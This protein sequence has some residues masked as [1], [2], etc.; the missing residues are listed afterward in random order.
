MNTDKTIKCIETLLH[1]LNNGLQVQSRSIKVVLSVEEIIEL[2]DSWL[3]EKSMGH[4]KKPREITR[5][6][7]MLKIACMLYGKMEHYSLGYANNSELS[8]KFSDKADSAFERAIEFIR[9]M[10]TT[11][12]ELS[13]WLD[14]DVFV[15]A[16]CSPF[17][18]PRIVGSKTRE[19]LNKSNKPYRMMTKRQLKINFL[20]KK[21][22]QLKDGPLDE[23]M[24]NVDFS[25]KPKKLRNNDFSGFIF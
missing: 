17:G 23:F 25:I 3:D 14:R 24:C 20:E 18:V 19:C 5:Y 16:S 22:K 2:R 6:G 15:V 13:I 9:D 21:L 8:K 1:R 7:E 4:I 11:D 10:V 12:R